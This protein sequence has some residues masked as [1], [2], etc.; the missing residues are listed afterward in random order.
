[1][2]QDKSKDSL[3]DA[4]IKAVF[5]ANVSRRTFLKNTGVTCV[6]FVGIGG[7]GK[8]VKGRELLRPPGGQSEI[9]F[10]ASCL[11]CDRC[12]S[13]CPKSAIDLASLS[14]GI[15][16]ARTP[17]MN[18]HRGYCNFCK[19]CVEVCPTNALKAFNRDRVRIGQAEI[20]KDICIA[21]NTGGCTVCKDKCPYK[22]IT[23]DQEKR[24]VVDSE[25]CNGCGVC[26]YNCPAL[27]LRSYIGGKVRG[28]VVTP[29]SHNVH[30][31]NVASLFRSL[32]DLGDDRL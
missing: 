1:M 15:L 2:G 22:A 13:I 32:T 6:L 9:S 4:K 31:T 27:V 18:Y 28:I 11:K 24:P 14:D 30:T 16:A 5:P 8:L 17:V 19:K 21:W 26:E 23:L 29:V 20:K 12:S 25:K 7:A 10:I 3:P